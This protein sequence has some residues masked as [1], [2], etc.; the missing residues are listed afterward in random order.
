MDFV[1]HERHCLS[2][3]EHSQG[4]ETIILIPGHGSVRRLWVPL[5][6]RLADLGRWVTL[7]LPGHYPA[8]VPEDY[9]TLSVDQLIEMELE[10]IERISRGQP[11]TLVGHS[12]GALVALGVAARRPAL[13]RRLVTLN[14]L[15]WGPPGGILRAGIWALKN[16]ID[17]LFHTTIALSQVNLF[18]SKAFTSC[19]VHNQARFWRSEQAMDTCA[20]AYEWMRHQ[21]PKGLAILL[22]TISDCDIRSEVRDLQLPT[23]VLTG[24]CDKIVSPRQSQW[25]AQN[26]PTAEYIEL[27]GVGHMP[28]LEALDELVATLR[29][30]L[31]P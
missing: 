5:V 12:T 3:E 19:Y 24:T 13:I 25:L 17:P 28:N 31:R 2:W 20:A 21:S 1:Q 14:G 27:Q 23:L 4:A 9:A 11:V 10:A 7:D 30:W 26:L 16:Q 15:V 29:R 6:S 8:R 18:S 22:R